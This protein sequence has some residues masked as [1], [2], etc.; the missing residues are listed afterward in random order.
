MYHI[1]IRGPLGIGKTTIAKILCKKLNLKYISFDQVLKD[2][3]LDRKDDKFTASDYIRANQI[4]LKSIRS[5][6]V[7]DGCFYFRQQITHLKKHLKG[8]V[9][10]FTLKASLKTC[11]ARDKG[12]KKS[13]GKDAAEAVYVMVN[14]FDYG[15]TIETDD[16]TIKEVVNDIIGNL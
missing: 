4:V 5:S 7:F 12:R 13:Y 3:G 10:V 6:T 9:Y 14:R 15:T 2:N 8:K 1:I 11:M 16:K